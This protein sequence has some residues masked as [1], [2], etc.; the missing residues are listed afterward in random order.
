M[1]S[2]NKIVV[3]EVSVEEAVKINLTIPEF[4]ARYNTKDYFEDRYKNKDTLII[5]AY[6][7]N[8]PAGYLIG[9]DRFSDKSFYCWMAGVKPEF[10]EMGVLKA[11]MDYEESWAKARGYKKIR[12]KTRNNRREMLAYLIKY[13]FYFTEVETYP[14]I[15]ENRILAEKKL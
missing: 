9:Y 13:G 8:K 10:R 14:N 7:D 4:E 1:P 5:M 6:F 11:L 2:K 12:I 15:E 3:K